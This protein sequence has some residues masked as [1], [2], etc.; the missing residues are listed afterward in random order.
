MPSYG[1]SFDERPEEPEKAEML[2]PKWQ[3]IWELERILDM[4]LDVWGNKRAD[5]LTL[6]DLE[7]IEEKLEENLEVEKGL[8]NE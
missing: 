4:E 3:K 2:S 8:I 5:S 7:L 6:D 1:V